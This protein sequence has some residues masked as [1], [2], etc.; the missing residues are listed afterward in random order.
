[1]PYHNI[2]SD[3]SGDGEMVTDTWQGDGATE[4]RAFLLQEDWTGEKIADTTVD[5]ARSRLP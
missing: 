2:R 4:R 5:S 1:M 3:A